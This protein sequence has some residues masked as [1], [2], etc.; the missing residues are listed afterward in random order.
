MGVTSGTSTE[1]GIP[2]CSFVRASPQLAA[3]RS[4]L[5]E[6]KGVSREQGENA[7]CGL[8][9]LVPSANRCHAAFGTEA[10]VGDRF[11]ALV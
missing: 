6:V 3:P 1:A 8:H 4:P 9:L 2:R 10:E 11:V 5:P 7:R